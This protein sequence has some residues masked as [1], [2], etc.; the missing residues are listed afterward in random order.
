MVMDREK[1]ERMLQGI[2]GDSLESKLMRGRIL[3]KLGRLEEAYDALN[4][5][6]VFDAFFLR[7]RILVKLNKLKDAEAE[8]RRAVE[9]YPYNH[10]LHYLLARLERKL[11]EL[12]LALEEIN[13]ALEIM[14]ISTTYLLLKTKILF[15]M[16]LYEDVLQT[17]AEVIRNR[18]DDLRVRVMRVLSYYYLGS[19]YNAL[20]EVNRALNYSKHHYLHFLKGKIYL[21][22]GHHS[23]ALDEFKIAA[24]AKEK[25]EYLYYASLALYLIKRYSESLNFID[26]ALKADG[27]NPSYLALKAK[28]LWELGDKRAKEL[29]QKAVS[30]DKSLLPILKDVLG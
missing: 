9:I 14:P 26:R 24:H 25:P 12:N 2:K 28:V 19:R 11:G 18:P 4:G 7:F 16:E 21:E 1:L 10:Y 13:R 15:D 29:A 5:V 17:S 3:Y 23:L 6:E 20:V 30:L 27:Q 8:L 22:M